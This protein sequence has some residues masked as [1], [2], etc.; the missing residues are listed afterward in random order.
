[1]YIRIYIYI[2]TICIVLYIHTY[3][4]T[5]IRITSLRGNHLSNTICLTQVFFKSGE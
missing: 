2:Y 3:T 5:S 4:Y 1:M